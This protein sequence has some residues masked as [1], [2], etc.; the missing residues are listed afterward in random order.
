MIAATG[1]A[2]VLTEA[3]HVGDLDGLVAVV[4]PE[5]QPVTRN[6][7]RGKKRA[8]E[9]TRDRYR[10]AVTGATSAFA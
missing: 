3:L 9:C 5:P 7:A 10:R 4:Q 1:G 6:G 2:D 8:E